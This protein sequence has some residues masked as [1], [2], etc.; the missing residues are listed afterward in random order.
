[1]NARGNTVRTA[2]PHLT[3]HTRALPT[4]AA[5][6]HCSYD[7]PPGTRDANPAPAIRKGG[8]DTAAPGSPPLTGVPNEGRQTNGCGTGCQPRR[9]QWSQPC[10]RG[11]PRTA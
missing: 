5:Q 2:P 1:M 6:R 11:P 4:A 3:R 7:I 10:P 8:D 9:P